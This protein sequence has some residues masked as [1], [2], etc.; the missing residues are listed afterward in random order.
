LAVVAQRMAERTRQKLLALLKDD[1]PDPVRFMGRLG[2]MKSLEDV[3][4]FS[5]A[6]HLLVHLELGDVE[7]EALLG[8]VLRHRSAISLA[9]G[10][11]PG[12][13]V[14]AVDYLS[15]VDRRLVNPKI[16][17]LSEFERTERCAATD[18]LTRLYN[19]R[20]F[21]EAL[22][23]EVRRSRRYGL[24][25]SVAML[26]LDDFKAI[27]DLYGHLFGDAVLERV[28][29]LVRRAI[30]EADL[31]CRYGGEEIALI[32]PET[33]RLGAY[34]VASR[35]RE[36]VET[37]FLEEPTGGRVVPMTISGGVATYPEDG[38]EP[39]ALVARADEALYIAKR[40]GKNRITLHHQ[41]RRRSVRYPARP[42]ARLRVEFGE[43]EA[44]EPAMAINLSRNG[45]LLETGERVSLASPVVLFMGRDRV[46]P[47]DGDW[48][49]N[50]RVVR[51]EPAADA[52]SRFRIGVAFDQ[53]VA[54]E[55]LLAQA[56]GV[57][58]P[59]RAARGAER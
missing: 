1:H 58:Q 15:N 52:A 43:Q 38:L 47:P 23:R 13:R 48:V 4:A 31:A 59:L 25:L 45:A 21:Q 54:E 10:R 24:R 37:S 6:I 17:E 49:V 7:A 20:L 28:S 55:C 22:D 14:A 3:P 50:A 32:L 19:R 8:E 44:G 35:V 56:S 57:R 5:E 40:A 9:L 33:E 53:P 42:R 46:G 16:V 30:R 12:L 29:K 27:N 2:E 51:V 36:R 26:D 41:E 18:P 11:D 39:D 34:A